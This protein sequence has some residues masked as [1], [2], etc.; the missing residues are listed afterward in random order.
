MGCCGGKLMR[1]LALSDFLPDFAVRSLNPQSSGNGVGPLV[2][3]PEPPAAAA[4][5][6]AELNA[7]IREVVAKAEAEITGRLSAIYEATLQAERDKHAAELER[8][9]ADFG[10]EIGVRISAQLD[11]LEA[12]VGLVATSL[13]G[14]IIS[15]LLTEDIQKRSLESLRRSIVEAL[16]DN[17]TVRI[18][19]QGPLSLFEP[20]SAALGERAG[21]LQYVE[22]PG[23]DLTVSIDGNLFET[24]L[25]E[26]S[27]ALAGAL[28]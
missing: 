28:S 6:A 11:E 9:Q 7:L 22:A 17:D 4:P 24:R 18:Q 2:D 14:R 21:S 25:C 20:L 5:A 8:L 15:S 19:V 1:A 23:F 10:T 27:T 16:R 13:T 26:W 3:H 12:S